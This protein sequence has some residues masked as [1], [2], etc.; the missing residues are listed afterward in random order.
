MNQHWQN[1]ATDPFVETW[2]LIFD[3]GKPIV[4]V[5]KKV[6][7]KYNEHLLTRH[8]S[9]HKIYNKDPD[10][11]FCTYETKVVEPRQR[12]ELRQR[13]PEPYDEIDSG[14]RSLTPTS[15]GTYD[16][17]IPI[18]TQKESVKYE[19]ETSV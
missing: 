3:V 1:P 7:D 11:I 19:N 12:N 8:I 15:S 10:C 6:N 4:E 17:I 18:E 14:H 2:Q 9:T 5:V 13:L 16:S